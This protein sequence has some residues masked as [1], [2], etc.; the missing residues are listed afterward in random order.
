MTPFAHHAVSTPFSR[1]LTDPV[2]DMPGGW[3]AFHGYGSN[4]ALYNS[5]SSADTPSL[6]EMLAGMAYH[7]FR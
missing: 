3:E 1:E 5:S 7:K 2:H 6:M 4:E